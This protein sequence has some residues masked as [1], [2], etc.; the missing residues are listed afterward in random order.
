MESFSLAYTISQIE[1]R[2]GPNGIY[3]N[4]N[5]CLSYREP[6]NHNTYTYIHSYSYDDLYMS[7]HFCSADACVHLTPQFDRSYVI[8]IVWLFLVFDIAFTLHTHTHAVYS[9]R[10]RRGSRYQW[11]LDLKRVDVRVCARVHVWRTHLNGSIT[12]NIHTI[13]KISYRSFVRSINVQCLIIQVRSIDML[14]IGIGV[15][16]CAASIGN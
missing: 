2:F 14:E 5:G 8:F 11:R 3:N 10:M 6:G 13:Y 15:C 16:V 9:S 12:L 4:N 1:N 7:F